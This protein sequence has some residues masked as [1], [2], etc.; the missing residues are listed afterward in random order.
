MKNSLAA[1][2]NALCRVYPS[3][4]EDIHFLWVKGLEHAMA[5]ARLESGVYGSDV[6]RF[7]IFKGP[8]I[9]SLHLYGDWGR[10]V[11][12]GPISSAQALE[13]LIAEEVA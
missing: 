10:V 8:E 1:A 6:P 2:E 5:I 7:K 4:D 3:P 11:V 9:W 12:T 13:A